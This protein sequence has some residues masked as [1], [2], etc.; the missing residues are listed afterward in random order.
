MQSSP[1]FFVSSLLFCLITLVIGGCSEDI[2][3]I[4][5][6]LPIPVVYAVFDVNKAVHYVKVS[7]TFAGESDPYTLAGDPDNIYYNDAEVFLTEGNGST[8]IPFALETGIP[9]SEGS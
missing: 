4:K 8:R 5:P 1:R 3:V 9:R 7:K 6:G 2:Q